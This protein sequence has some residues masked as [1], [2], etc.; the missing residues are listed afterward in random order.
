MLISLFLL[1]GM[2]L[3]ISPEMATTSGWIAQDE[4]EI[5]ALEDSIV[6]AADLLQNSPDVQ[7]RRKASTRIM[8][9]L[10]QALNMN[11]SWDYPFDRVP[12]I[13]VLLPDDKT[14]RLFTWQLYLDPDHYQHLGLMQLKKEPN[15]PIR[16]LDRSGE[17]VRL[18]STIG[19]ADHWLGAVY[20]KIHTCEYKRKK[21]WLLFGFDGL[22]S[23]SKRKII[24]VLHLNDDDQPVFGDPV[25]QYQD[26][27]GTVV[28]EKHRLVLDYATGS[29]VRL[30]YDD[31]YKMILFDHLMPFA[32]ERNGL[33]L[34]NIP[35]GT[36][37]GFKYEKGVWVHVDKVFDKVMDE[38]PVDFPVLN[39]RKG[40][41]IFGK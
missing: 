32:D 11:G 15:R 2:Y 17:Y 34:V 19:S 6:V 18:E 16:L 31:H 21:Y 13:S 12:Q 7:V 40:K 27:E 41:N 29:H 10:T 14:Y 3:P 24:D 23:T 25:F 36:Y 22:E 20:Y 37:E 39:D 38:A 5:S 1:F 35:D 4:I 28:K 8:A 33:G 26:G 9:L 30:N